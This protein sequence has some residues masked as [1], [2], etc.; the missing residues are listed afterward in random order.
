MLPAYNARLTKIQAGAGGGVADGLD[1]NQSGIVRWEGD[2]D[3]YILIKRRR[4]YSGDT[5]QIEKEIVIYVPDHTARTAGLVVGDYLTVTQDGTATT[6]RAN[7]VVSSI[8]LD[9]LGS[10][11]VG[12]ERA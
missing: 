2:Q 3:A 11:K 6:Y 4:N 10:V 8:G 1:T 9:A 12:V 5:S 7:D